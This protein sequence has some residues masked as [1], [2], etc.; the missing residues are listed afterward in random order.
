MPTLPHFLLT[1]APA[2]RDTDRRRRASVRRRVR[3][4][5]CTQ[6]VLGACERSRSHGHV[7]Q[8]GTPR[9]PRRHPEWQQGGTF[10]RNVVA[11][12]QTTYPAYDFRTYVHVARSGVISFHVYFL[13]CAPA[14]Y[15]SRR[16]I[17]QDCDRFRA[18]RVDNV[19]SFLSTTRAPA[20]LPRA[21]SSTV[22][23]PERRPRTGA[24]DVRSNHST[25]S[26][27]PS[28]SSP[29]ATA[30]LTCTRGRCPRVP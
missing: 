4:E 8:A 28:H 7:G 27:P 14:R 30:W 5:G 24:C 11:R 25:S 6:G 16:R 23:R 12:T 17:I 1:L 26:Q 2:A 19:E 22:A 21:P 18:R 29:C 15:L 3:L 13:N 20:F 10:F 9:R